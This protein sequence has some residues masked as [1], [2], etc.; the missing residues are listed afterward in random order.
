MIKKNILRLITIGISLGI[1]QMVQA[2]AVDDQSEAKGFID[3]ASAKILLRNYYFNRNA[4]RGASDRIDWTQATRGTFSSGFTQGTVGVGVDAF[5]YWGMKLD[6]GAGTAG[7]GNL[8]VDRNGDPESEFGTAGGAV[9]LRLSK[10]QLNYGNLQPTAPVMAAGGSRLFPQTA[11]GWNLFSSEFKDLD[12]EAGHFTSSNGPTTT[13]SDHQ[14]WS[15]YANVAGRSMDYVGAKYNVNDALQVSLYGSEFRDIWRQYY[16]NANYILGL[17]SDQSLAFDFNI[18][19]MLD[20]GQAKAGP[21]N[22]TTWSFSSAYSFLTA[23]TLTLAVQK[24]NG[25]TPMDYVSYGSNGAGDSGDS[26]Y[27]ANSVIYSDFD[28]PGERS[29]QGR[30]DLNMTSYGVP[31]LSFMARYIHGDNIDGTR[32]PA[33]SPYANYGYGEDGNHHEIDVEARYV[34]QTGPAKDLSFRLRQ[35]WHRANADQAEGDMN[36]FR[37]IIDYPITLL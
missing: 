23:H 35:A 20:T 10:T 16:A 3:D 24:V 17:P 36:E 37:L 33:G 21:I 4:M 18:Y 2:A 12:L 11:T 30:Y 32:L 34:V 28:G 13:N 22:N 6:G 5:G 26:I 31:G 19:R 14:L 29:W 7:T 8:P 15:V 27:L 1:N 9:K 25:D